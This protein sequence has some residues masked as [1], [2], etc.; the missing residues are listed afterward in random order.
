MEK[1]NEE[2]A[3]V[4]D[5]TKVFPFLK[6][7]IKELKDALKN[8]VPYRLNVFQ[9]I[10]DRFLL[11]GERKNNTHE[12]VFEYEFYSILIDLESVINAFDKDR[13]NVL[14]AYDYYELLGQLKRCYDMLKKNIE[15]L[16]EMQEEE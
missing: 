12:K 10:H 7:K 4:L 5:T 14:K 15:H 8:R 16:E 6:T 1:W 3:L 11:F 2:N 9:N 13:R